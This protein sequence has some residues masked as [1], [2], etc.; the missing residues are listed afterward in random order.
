MKRPSFGARLRRDRVTTA[1][2]GAYLL[3]YLVSQLF[4]WGGEEL[5]VALGVSAFLPISFIAA[6]LGL[7]AA[8][9]PLLDAATRR[10]WWLVSIAL[11]TY[12]LGG[13]VRLY[14]LALTGMQTFPSPADAFQLAFYP[15]LLAAT[16]AFPMRLRNGT[17]R[18]KFWLDVATVLVGGGMVIAYFLLPSVARREQAALTNWVSFGYV[19]GALALFLA[20]AILLSKRPPPETGWA[21]R[22]LVGGLIPLLGADIAIANL[23]R[24]AFRGDWSDMLRLCAACLLLCSTYYQSRLAGRRPGVETAGP[25][26]ARSLHWLPYSS[27]VAG[28]GLLMAVAFTGATEMLDAVIVGS[29]ALTTLVV[30]RQVVAVR[31]SSRLL[32]E[33]TARRSEARFSSLIQNSSDVVAVVGLDGVVSYLTPSVERM[34][35]YE[36]TDLV[37][38]SLIDLAHPDDRQRAAIYVA[39]VVSMAGGAPASEWRIRHR[40]GSWLHV[41]VIGTNLLD[42]PNV[43]GVVLNL[44][45][46]TQRKALEDQLTHQAFHDPLTGLAN[47]ALFRD[48][49]EHALR[50]RRRFAG[51]VAVLFLDLDDFKT[52]NDSR[53]H[54]VGDRLLVEVA[55]RLG[56]CLRSGDT[57]ARLGG[58]EFAVLLED[59]SDMAEAGTVAERIIEALREPLRLE[60]CGMSISASIGIALSGPKDGPD[61]LLRNADVAMYAAKTSGK[62][63]YELFEPEMHEAILGRLAMKAELQGALER[64][65]FSVYYQPTVTLQTGRVTGVEALVR[66][67]HPTRGL[68]APAE[69]IPLAEE[70]GLI[71]PLGRWVLQEAV[72]QV[73]RWQQ[74]HPSQ[75]PLE[76]NV[77]LS[78]RQLQDPELVRDVARALE[79]SGLEP[80]CLVLEITESVLM[81]DADVAVARLEEIKA[82]GARLAVDDFG[83]GYSSLAYLRRFPVDILKIDKVFVDG[84]AEEADASALANAVIELGRALDLQVVAEGIELEGQLDRLR[85]LGCELG[86][87]YF[88]SRPL[89]PDAA[90]S[91]LPES[92]GATCDGRAPADAA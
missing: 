75:P 80:S 37:G 31:E 90:A 23:E 14:Q 40:D 16:L 86:Q 49:V 29:V 66:W 85:E 54:M 71:V 4:G 46:V 59:A 17:E 1:A 30:A 19:A 45:D 26:D 63:H 35:G 82:L 84:V 67:Q 12:T 73:R 74:D 83:T 78:P 58:D 2:L 10:A 53:G 50:R 42:D 72:E 36:P 76:V 70:S 20:I 55:E 38:S 8:V 69:F 61:E 77:N 5:R 11:L 79:T 41:E 52:V 9:G 89:P 81:Q 7:R 33:S 60:D 24:G 43:G 27:I 62:A 34:F 28:Y 44:H 18:L 21:S 87:G 57:A 25:Q 92:D 56:S 51:S 88:W 68:I 6:I 15:L 65:E 39:E 64:G 32:A 47:R 3:V 13:V 48:R 22:L 91:L